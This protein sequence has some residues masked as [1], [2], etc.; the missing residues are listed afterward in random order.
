M[1]IK[2]ARSF[3]LQINGDQ[4]RYGF[5]GITTDDEEIYG[6]INSTSFTVPQGKKLR[7]LYLIVMGAPTVHYQISMPTEENASGT[8]REFPY[9]FRVS[10]DTTDS[11]N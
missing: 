5:L 1:D 9:S 3:G 6:D 10:A 4:L 11:Q 2:N 8:L 7:H